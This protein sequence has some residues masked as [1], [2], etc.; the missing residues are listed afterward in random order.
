[1]GNRLVFLRGHYRNPRLVMVTSSPML[2]QPER[3]ALEPGRRNRF[4][5]D[6]WVKQR[7]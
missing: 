3:L 7:G 6:V 5:G 2:Y 1:M 4:L